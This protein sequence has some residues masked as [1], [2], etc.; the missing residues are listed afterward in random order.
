M[1]G[2]RS[3]QNHLVQRESL[4]VN[5]YFNKKSVVML[6]YAKVLY[7][8]VV[9][10][11]FGFGLYFLFR[12]KQD[13]LSKDV[14]DFNKKSAEWNE[15]AR[16]EFED[17]TISIKNEKNTTLYLENEVSKMHKY[18]DMDSIYYN[19]LQKVAKN[20]APLISDIKLT[21]RKSDK[22]VRYY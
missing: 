18:D 20:L 2:R 15:S 19:P 17:W 16:G 12:S 21:K 14:I 7:G 22:S 3:N 13:D 6:F 10:V 4:T 8:V 11:L 9:F 1:E 5:P